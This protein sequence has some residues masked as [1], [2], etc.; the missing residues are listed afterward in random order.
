MRLERGATITGRVLGA[1]G[2]KAG[3]VEVALVGASDFARLRT[4]S[5]ADGSYALRGVPIGEAQLEFG[6][7]LR[8][9]SVP[10]A[11]LSRC[12]LRPGR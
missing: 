6:G 11:G 9:V 4:R 10:R 3:G 7:E 8:R 5:S 2:V 1:D 12:D